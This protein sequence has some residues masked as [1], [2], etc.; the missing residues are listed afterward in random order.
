[1]LFKKMIRE[2]NLG[3]TNKLYLIFPEVYGL[4]L[5]NCKTVQKTGDFLA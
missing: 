4:H 2:D 1:M 3:D 5:K